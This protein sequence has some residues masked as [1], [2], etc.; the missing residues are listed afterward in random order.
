M[1]Q[2]LIQS[3]STNISSV[4]NSYGSMAGG[5]IVYIR[6]FGFSTDS[7]LNS[8]LIGPYPCNPIADGA[9]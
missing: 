9:T 8:I 1:S 5:T 7:S 4:V 6:G 3:I 2:P